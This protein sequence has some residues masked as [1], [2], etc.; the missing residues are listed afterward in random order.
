MSDSLRDQLIAAGFKA[1]PKKK[2]AA[3]KK[4][5]QTKGK[6]KK[7]HQKRNPT[8]DSNASKQKKPNPEVQTEEIALRKKLKA[9]IK[10]LIEDNKI[11]PWKGETVFRYLVDRRIREMYVNDAVH[12]RLTQREVSVTRLNGD[13]YLVPFETG[14]EIIKINPQW[15]VFNAVDETKNK[16][17]ND[18]YEDFEVPDD[19]QW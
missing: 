14:E 17:T 10:K 4:P 3:K 8:R 5:P 2:K 11:E 16:S 12:K 6:S 13:T 15:S 7:P 19:L 18:G 1:P 9:Q